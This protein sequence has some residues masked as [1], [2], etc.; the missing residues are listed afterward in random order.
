MSS[1][2]QP[3]MKVFTS[4]SDLS[5]KQF[6]FVKLASGTSIAQAAADEKAIGVAMNN[7]S[8]GGDAEVALLGGGALVKIAGPITAG[9]SIKSDVNGA[10]VVAS[11]NGD[12]CPAIA[13]E[14]GVAGDVI[15]VLLDG[16]F[17]HS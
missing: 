14:S 13:L 2:V 10:G 8:V 3:E 15:S 9:Q 11:S 7:P 5:S 12:W 6:H 1:Y 17:F 4:N 16:H